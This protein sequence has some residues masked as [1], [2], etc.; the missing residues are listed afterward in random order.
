MFINLINPVLLEF[1]FISIRWYG[2]FLAIG[3]TLAILIITKLFK[4]KKYSVDLALD[5]GIWLTIGGL[6]GA[7]L[8]EIL[9]Y[10]PAY[11]FSNPIEMIFINHGGLSSHGMTI[12]LILTLLL[13]AKIKSAQGGSASGGKIPLKQY[14]DLIVLPIPLLAAFIRIGN[15]FNSEIVGKPTALPWGV[16]FPLYEASPV[17]RHPSQLY[18]SLISLSLF[19]FLYFVYK[20]YGPKLPQL[21]LTNLFLLLYF[22]SRFLIEFL[23]ADYQTSLGLTMGQI[24]S[25]PF[26]LWSVGWFIIFLK[27]K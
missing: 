25:A 15:F 17:A 16:K 4:E 10:E 18:E 26:I 22:S 3:V 8:G 21:F 5:L 19:I 20:K 14:L 7:R 9:F 27:N 12:G 23:K 24:L 11:Y 1:G 13:F 6:L 2:L